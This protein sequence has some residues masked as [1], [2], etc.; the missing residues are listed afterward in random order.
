MSVVVLENTSV[1]DAGLEHL[2]ETAS[3][4]T[5]LVRRTKVTE[6]GVKKLAALPLCRIE[7]EG[8]VTGPKK[9]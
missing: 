9:P 4:R 7:W 8:G 5:L 6:T 2:R 3:L 1:G